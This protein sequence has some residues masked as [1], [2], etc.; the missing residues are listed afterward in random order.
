MILEH[1][2]TGNEVDEIR[3]LSNGFIPPAGA[4]EPVIC[5]CAGLGA[6]DLDMSEHVHFE[7]HLVF[8]GA[9]AL[10]EQACNHD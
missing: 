8:P 4:P 9:I 10:E 3:R 6:F 1:E 7:D 2:Q 5:L